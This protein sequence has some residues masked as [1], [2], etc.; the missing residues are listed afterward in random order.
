MPTYHLAM[1]V[2]V[3]RLE[4]VTSDHVVLRYDLAGAGN[5]GFAALFD[6]V[7]ASA[8]T[9]GWITA[10]SILVEAT[11]GVLIGLVLF[12]AVV[13]GWTYF[14]V[15]EWLW[16]GQTLGKRLFGLRVINEDGSPARF[17]AVFV[18]NLVRVVD[19]LPGFYGF[20]LVCVVLSSR[21]QRLGDLAAGT[22]VVRARHPRVD[23]L[24][25]RTLDGGTFGAGKTRA[26]RTGGSGGAGEAGPARTMGTTDRHLHVGGLSG[27]AQRLVRE[28]VVREAKLPR[29]E[30][31]RLAARI[32]AHLRERVPDS[33]EA[34]DVEL[35]RAV[36][37]SLRASGDH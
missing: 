8:L 35:I 21:S 33:A 27:E 14:I 36:A 3:G 34:D 10:W 16:N 11:G 2:S 9:L 22:Y 37:R 24:A 19:F 25:L 17:I 5:R 13:F 31:E 23:W 6:F 20:G 32:A 29:A 7:V 15:L 1:A 26:E 28:F 12:T 4:V 18:R 30:R